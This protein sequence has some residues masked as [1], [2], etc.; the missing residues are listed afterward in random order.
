MIV[1]YF[2][3]SPFSF[4][5]NEFRFATKLLERAKYRKVMTSS[6][7]DCLFSVVQIN[8]TDQCSMVCQ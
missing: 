1:F 7:N 3:S 2:S 6:R 5:E 8:V 4:S